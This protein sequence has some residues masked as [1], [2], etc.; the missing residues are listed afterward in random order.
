MTKT[1][2]ASRHAQIYPWRD[3]DFSRISTGTLF[4]YV[5]AG[6]SIAAGMVGWGEMV[7]QI[8]RY[9]NYY[10]KQKEFK[11]F[12]DGSPESNEKFL[13]G[14]VQAETKLKNGK[15]VRILS[16]D[17]A[18]DADEDCALGR[19]VLL[20]LLLRSRGPS[21]YLTIRQ[22]EAIPD[23]EKDPRQRAGKQPSP[24]D[25][26]LQSLI[27]RSHCHGVLTTNY[28][29]LLE[30]AFSASGFGTSLRTYRYTADFLRFI[31]SN[32]HF[33][34]KMHGDIN[35]LRTIE[36]RPISAW[37]RGG[38]SKEE[39]R[40][41]DLKR[42][43]QTALDRGHMIYLGCGFCDET[44]N[45][46]HKS[47][48][49]TSHAGLLSRLAIVPQNEITHGSIDPTNYPDIEFLTWDGDATSEVRSFLERIVSERSKLQS[50]A[51]VCPEASDIHEQV[52]MSR[53]A[54]ELRRRMATEH[55]TCKGR[56]PR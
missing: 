7:C 12:L 44:I 33:V 46:L 32:P 53:E 50:L 19:V 16:H 34:L 10:E 5:G 4:Y 13:E 15:S 22:G 25:L 27:W 23:P 51:T 20:N 31:L 42:V 47:W 40:G 54:H 24:E 14:F 11:S 55:W 37:D 17:S 8:W 6:L 2:S 45:Q 1:H 35:D 43:Y 41:E 18:F 52:F 56:V 49:P 36:F 21:V 39:G 30:H 29:V 3:F 28:D 26:A 38:L 9:L 48:Q